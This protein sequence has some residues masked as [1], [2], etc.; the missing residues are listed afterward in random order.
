MSPT[1][2]PVP[3]RRR[4]G[5]EAYLL[6]PKVTLGRCEFSHQRLQA[7]GLNP[8]RLHFCQLGRQR[9]K[10]QGPKSSP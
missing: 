10:Q 1:Q 8:K 4:R 9:R 6:G 7:F 3:Q 2:K 5:K